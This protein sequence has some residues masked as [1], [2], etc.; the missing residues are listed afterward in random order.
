MN[1]KVIISVCIGLAKSSQPYVQI[2]K[3]ML[4]KYLQETKNG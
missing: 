2:V 4:K 1:N 3:P